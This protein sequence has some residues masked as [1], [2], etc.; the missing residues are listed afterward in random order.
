MA[1]STCP[2]DTTMVHPSWYHHPG[3]TNV[4]PGSATG[5]TRHAVPGTKVGRGALYEIS[6]LLPAEWIEFGRDY[7]DLGSTSDGSPQ[8]TVTPPSVHST[9]IYPIL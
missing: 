3:Y 6:R 7:L 5:A 1:W 4:M 2:G 8:I 9:L